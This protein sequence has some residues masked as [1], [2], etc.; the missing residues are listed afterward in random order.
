MWQLSL[1][2][3]GY[4]AMLA[5]AAVYW[6]SLPKLRFLPLA[7]CILVGSGSELTQRDHDIWKLAEVTGGWTLVGLLGIFAI[8][9][10]TFQRR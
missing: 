9:I 4:L 6:E 8:W 5:I 10:E 2:I 3:G 7:Y 1:I